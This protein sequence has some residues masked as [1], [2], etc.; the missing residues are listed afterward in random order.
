MNKIIWKPYFEKSKNLYID[1]YKN[2]N[3][4]LIF[5]F[6]P[7]KFIKFLLITIIQNNKNLL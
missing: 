4:Y 3:K 5:R 6:G 2:Y 7:S 1:V